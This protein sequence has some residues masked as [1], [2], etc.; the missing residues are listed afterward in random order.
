[1]DPC[2][3]AKKLINNFHLEKNWNFIQADDLK[4]D[5]D[6]PIDHLFIDT[7]HTYEQTLAELNKFG[8]FVR[9]GGIITLH[10]II[11]S[12]EVLDAIKEYSTNRNDM[13][14]Y[15]YYHNNGLGILKIQK[16]S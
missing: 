10:D 6:K 9:P 2:N 7:S 15:K 13:K 8:S 4:L 12:H 3:E 16:S 11:S 5:W 14:F 1:M